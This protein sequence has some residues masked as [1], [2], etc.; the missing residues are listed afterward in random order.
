MAL[1]E[2][3]D[4]PDTT[5]PLTAEN[6][7]NNFEYLNEKNNYSTEEK[8][9]GVFKSKPLYRQIIEISELG[10]SGVTKNINLNNHDIE[11]SQVKN[12]NVFLTDRNGTICQINPVWF[13]L[14]GTIQC[15][16]LIYNSGTTNVLRIV[17]AS[18]VDL[19]S[20]SAWAII[21]YTKTTD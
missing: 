2:F 7:N 16:C 6:L 15:R 13:A 3:K 10:A 14:D 19:S 18:G 4:L 20:C 12:F 21:E 1:I 11:G 5:T 8:I 17:T 9:I